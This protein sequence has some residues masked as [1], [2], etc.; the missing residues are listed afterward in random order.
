MAQRLD[1]SFVSTNIPGAY[2]E[3]LVK[4]T[5]VGV[6]SSGIIAIIGEADG[7]EGF[8]TKALKDSIYS[9]A[10][11]AEVQRAYVSGDIVDAM[12]ALSAPSADD[13]IKGSANRIVILKTNQGDKAEAE[14]DTDYGTLRDK[15]WGTGGNKIKYQTKASRLEAVPTI[16]SD[17]IAALSNAGATAEV[18]TATCP[19]ASAITGGQYFTFQA[20]NNGTKYYG[21]FKKGG[22]GTDPAVAGRTGVEIDIG[23]SDANTVVATAVQGA[24]DALSTFSATV[25]SNVVTATAGTNGEAEDAANFNVGAGFSTLVTTQGGLWNASALNA[26]AFGI[27]PNGGAESTVTLSGTESDHDSAAELAA[28]IDGQLP[29][30][31]N[32]EASGAAAIRVFADADSAN[33]RRG[34]GKSFE[35]V[36][37]TP[38][39]LA[40]LGLDAGLVTSSAESK[41]ELD[42]SRNDTGLND[43]V[44]AS[45]DVALRVGYEGTTAVLTIADGILTVS[46]T[47]GSGDALSVTLADYVTLADLADY[48]S[49]KAGYTSQAIGAGVQASPSVLDEV[50]AIGA[51]STG[52]GLMPARIKRAASNWAKAISASRA[53]EFVAEAKSGL[54]TPMAVAKFLSGGAKGATSAANIVDALAQLEGASANFV[55]PL[56]S[57]DASDDIAEGL[58][59]STSAYTID[60]IH[61][62]TR[63]HCLKMSTPKMHRNRI[64]MLSFWGSYDDAKIKAQGTSGFRVNMCPQRAKALGSDSKIDTFNPWM[65]GSIAAGM[66]AA[67]FYKNITNKIANLAGFVDPDGFDSGNPGDVE[68]ALDAGLL[69]LNDEGHGPTWVSDQTTY[70]LDTNFV[71]NSLQAVYDADLISVDFAASFKRRFTGQSL[72]DIGSGNTGLAFI[73]EKMAAY[74]GQKLITSSDDAPL[75]YRNPKIS[76]SGPVMRVSVE[77][78]LSTAVYF[79]AITIELS[80]VQLSAG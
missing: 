52:A 37:S 69:I 54:P 38:G 77:V 20:G 6:T 8:A 5:P 45:G 9:P 79:E 31:L 41:V 46:K 42:T 59:D 50:S 12:R 17:A 27:R 72:A 2:A 34:W 61:A 66:Q 26:L 40:L 80:Q 55:I 39:D 63:S 24:I 3:T 48:I 58:T 76:I 65:A 32:C 67:G 73:Q 51:G 7:G 25:L 21:W 75:G 44:V 29:S 33:Y 43:T 53:V 35:L 1:E 19:A 74:K 11:L 47:G 71:Y 60:A 30:G 14:L 62:A 18:F 56:F 57:R 23:A 16:T 22:V 78:K 36:D 64:A 28:E 4:S 49:Q 70:G 10:Q 13:D 68:D 15:N